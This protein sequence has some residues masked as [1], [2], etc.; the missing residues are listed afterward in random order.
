MAHV[1]TLVAAVIVSFLVGLLL[2][3]TGDPISMLLCTATLFAT[4]TIF[5]FTGFLIGRR[6]L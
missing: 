4:A 3:P 5:H 1:L 6:K 2:S